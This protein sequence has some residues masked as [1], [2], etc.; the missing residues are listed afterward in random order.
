M[1]V[2]VTDDIRQLVKNPA[3]K[4]VKTG[5]AYD[6]VVD[7]R[8]VHNYYISGLDKAGEV[9]AKAFSARQPWDFGLEVEALLKKAGYTKISHYVDPR[10]G[11][12]GDFV[13]ERG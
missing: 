6:G 10:G 3:V 7:G 11:I 8:S 1:A 4:V 9:I 12:E 5:F 2:S 13:Y